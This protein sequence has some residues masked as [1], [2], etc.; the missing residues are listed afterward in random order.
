MMWE[1]EQEYQTHQRVNKMT[2]SQMLT[3][4]HTI[5]DVSASKWSIYPSQIQKLRETLIREEFYEL[6][7]A[8]TEENA[9]KEL[10]DLLYVCYGYAEVMGWDIETALKRVHISNLSKLDEVTGLPIRRKD[11]KILKG[12]NYKPPTMESLY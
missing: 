10:A 1:N 12:P 8:E 4:F 6:L 3:E 11:G 7:E 2:P 9:V 5:F